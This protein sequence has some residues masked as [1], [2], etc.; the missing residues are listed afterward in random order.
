MSKNMIDIDPA[1]IVFN[2]DSVDMIRT[3]GSLVA[4]GAHSSDMSG[5]LF[6]S[7]TEMSISPGRTA[8]K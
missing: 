1:A 6:P 4:R 3:G 2:T 5:S 8:G 7:A